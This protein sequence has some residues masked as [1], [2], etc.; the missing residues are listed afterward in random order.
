MHLQADN[1]FPV[2][3][4]AFQELFG[5]GLSGHLILISFGKVRVL[6]YVVAPPARPPPVIRAGIKIAPGILARLRCAGRGRYSTTWPDFCDAFRRIRGS[7]SRN[8]AHA[9]D[10]GMTS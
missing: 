10:V 2:T 8:H 1:N 3:G 4:C 9:A 6:Q 5:V 7:P